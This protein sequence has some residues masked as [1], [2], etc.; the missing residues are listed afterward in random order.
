MNQRM[1]VHAHGT[2]THKPI[3]TQMQILHTGDE[4]SLL[5]RGYTTRFCAA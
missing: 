2:H 1:Q 4:L 3:H 5:Q